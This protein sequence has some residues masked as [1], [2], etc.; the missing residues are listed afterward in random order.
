MSTDLWIYTASE[1][2]L[3]HARLHQALRKWHLLV[4][5]GGTFVEPGDVP[6]EIDAIYD[7][8]GAV[9]A[10][11]LKRARE[12]LK[13]R[14]RGLDKLYEKSGLN[15]VY[16]RVGP[17]DPEELDVSG[18]H[19]AELGRSKLRYEVNGHGGELQY[20]LWHALGKLIPGLMENP[21]SGDIKRSGPRPSP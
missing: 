17:V 5:K 20:D 15:S 12:I 2:P 19:A 7:V 4:K 21:Q 9:D 14:G 3:T 18:K 8:Y 11:V 13:K 16:L 10:A 1:D 6:L